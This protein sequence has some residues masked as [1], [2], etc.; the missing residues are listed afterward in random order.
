MV[1]SIVFAAFYILLVVI[2]PR[3][4]SKTMPS[5]VRTVFMMGFPILA[6]LAFLQ[7][8]LLGK[9]YVNL[10]SEE[11]ETAEEMLSKISVNVDLVIPIVIGIIGAVFVAVGMVKVL[12]SPLSEEPSQ[13]TFGVPGSLDAEYHKDCARSISLWG[14]IFEVI[15][16]IFGIG[17]IVNFVEIIKAAIS[18]SE[19]F[20]VVGGVSLWLFVMGLIIPFACILAFPLILYIY[21]GTA[22]FFVVSCLQQFTGLMLCGF[23]CGLLFTAAAV[24]GICASVR[25]KKSGSITIGKTIL[26]IIGSLIPIVNIF[27]LGNIRKTAR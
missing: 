10:L 14:I 11:F 26:Y 2:F 3:K 25:M 13:F 6:V 9:K 20:A 17:F 1:L 23:F 27:V 15:S 24:I 12:K 16:L 4:E 18:F 8:Y 22:F 19:V 7:A 5:V 21:A